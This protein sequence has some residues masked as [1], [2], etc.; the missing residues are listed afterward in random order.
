M[1]GLHVHM[2]TRYAMYYL[3]AGTALSEL[4]VENFPLPEELHQR[5]RAVSENCY[6]GRGF[7]VVQGLD[8]EKY[9]PEQTV[10][11]YAGISAH[12][13]PQHG[14][15]DKDRQKVLCELTLMFHG[16]HPPSPFCAVP[17]RTAVPASSCCCCY[18]CCCRTAA[19]QPIFTLLGF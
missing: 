7:S 4:K 1:Y 16:M 17:R 11:L 9:T 10:T 19:V 5:L 14:F 13:A 8:P 2:L 3:E 15:L 18:C 12:V 6:H